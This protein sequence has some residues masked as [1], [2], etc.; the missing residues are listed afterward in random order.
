MTDAPDLT[1]RKVLVVE[2]DYFI[3]SDMAAA[4][5]GAGAEVLGPCPNQEAMLDT[6][7]DADTCRAWFELGRW[8]TIQ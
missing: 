4:L 3:A 7:A 6:V 1:T 8:R 5:R 2:D